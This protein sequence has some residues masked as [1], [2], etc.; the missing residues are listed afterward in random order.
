MNMKLNKAALKHAKALIEGGKYIAD[1]DWSEAQ[2][3][4]GDESDYLDRHGWD[5]YGQWYLGLDPD[6]SKETKERHKFPYGDFKRVHRA[7]VIAAKQ[8][9]AQ[10]DY[11]DV[12]Q[13]A[14]ELLDLIDRKEGRAD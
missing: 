7:G 13:A 8:R 3:S 9:A 11:H 6:E 2:P 14:D 5:E 12:E 1:T 10:Y 4:A